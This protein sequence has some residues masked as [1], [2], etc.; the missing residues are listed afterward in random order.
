MFPGGSLLFDYTYSPGAGDKRRFRLTTWKRRLRISVVA[1]RISVVFV[2]LLISDAFVR[3]ADLRRYS[4]DFNCCLGTLAV[5]DRM[6]MFV[7]FLCTI[8]RRRLFKN[9]A[10]YLS[11]RVF[12]P[13]VIGQKCFFFC[14]ERVHKKHTNTLIRSTTAAAPKQYLKSV[15]YRRFLQKRRL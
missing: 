14:W 15:E 12:V 7:C 2:Q 8:F 6:S 13:S 3:S 10:Y 9:D 4:T 11:G 5:V 1:H